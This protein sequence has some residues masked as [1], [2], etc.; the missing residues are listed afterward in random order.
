VE[1]PTKE[2]DL[3]VHN[4]QCKKELD[5]MHAR[6]KIVLGDIEIMTTILKMTDCDAANKGVFIRI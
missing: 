3:K 1:I 6:L 4:A 2:Y 5:R